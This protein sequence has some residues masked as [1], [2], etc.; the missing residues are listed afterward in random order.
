MPD[1]PSRP[2]LPLPRVARAAG[3]AALLLVALS[4]FS[5]LAHPRPLDFL[6]FW[7]A[8]RLALAGDP[9]SAYDSAAHLALGRAIGGLDGYMTFVYPPPFLAILLPF[10]LMPFGVATLVWVCANFGIFIAAIRRA[11]PVGAWHALSFPPVLHNVLIGQAGLL[12][13]A[14]FALAQRWLEARPFRA[15]LLLGCLVLKPQLGLM[16]PIAL[17]AGA[18]WRAIGGAA[19]SAVAILLLGAMLFG[20]DSYRAMIAAMPDYGRLALESPLAHMKMASLYAALRH[21][22]LPSDAALLVHGAVASGVALLV[23]TAW[24]RPGAVDAKWMIL[25]CATAIAT[26]YALPYD[27]A[28]LILP[29][30]WLAR[31]GAALRLLVPLWCLTGLGLLTGFGAWNGPNLLPLATLGLFALTWRHG[32]SRSG[33]A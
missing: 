15:G 17:L 19:L 1:H 30:G 8:G 11:A 13:A 24:R 6:S 33:S 7:G 5:N 4:L 14:I 9:A 3:M 18:Q 12:V 16:L 32:V 10:A 28:F 29:F 22:G 2:G 25:L 20:P 21:S 26:P 31:Q 23:W 27:L